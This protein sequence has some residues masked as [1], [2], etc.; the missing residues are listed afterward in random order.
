MLMPQAVAEQRRQ[1]AAGRHTLRCTAHLLVIQSTR[2]C[3]MNASYPRYWCS[4]AFMTLPCSS[5]RQSA[6][7]DITGATALLLLL[8]E[9]R[10][11]VLLAIADQKIERSSR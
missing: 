11:R 6:L 9:Q 1:G 4:H 3:S 5:V 8:L 10:S 2:V 7:K